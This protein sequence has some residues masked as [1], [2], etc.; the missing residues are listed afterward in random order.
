MPRVRTSARRRENDNAR[1]GNDEPP[2]TNSER[3]TTNNE[4]RRTNI[5]ILAP[6]ALEYWSV[7]HVL[8]RAKATK[9]GVAASS[10]DL[11]LANCDSE[12]PTC[13]SESPTCDSES[14][15]CDSE[16]LTCDSSIILCGLAGGLIEGMKP[17]TVVIPQL[18]GSPDGSVTRCDAELQEAL[19]RG[20]RRLGHNP[21]QDPL[22]TSGALVTGSDRAA[23]TRKGFVA[24]DMEAGLFS[25][26]VQRFATVR[27]V[28]DT[29]QRSIS[30]HWVSPRRAMLRPAL[31]PELA[32]LAQAA[33]RYA[34]RAARVLKAGLELLGELELE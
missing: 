2:A 6:T 25:S 9:I 8:P 5:H 26:R 16:S 22:Y 33:P 32:W 27:V 24:A 1:M 3:R 4:Q 18:I 30:E 7:R 13:D 15:T 34:L 23:V 10:C 14:P 31:W 11:R 17:G 20:A 29:P 21:Q 19:V 12:S 28:L